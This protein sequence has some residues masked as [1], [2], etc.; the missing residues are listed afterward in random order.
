M[1]L[2]NLKSYQDFVVGT[3]HHPLYYFFI[4][5]CNHLQQKSDGDYVIVYIIII[6]WNFFLMYLVTNEVLKDTELFDFI[7]LITVQSN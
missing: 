7:L 1:Y 5:S 3:T 2:T 6:L 4:N